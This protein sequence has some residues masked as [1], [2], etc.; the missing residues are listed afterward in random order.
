MKRTFAHRVTAVG[1]AFIAILAGVAL[2]CFL[3]RQGAYTLCGL[4]AM[5]V[6]VV[7][8]ERTVHTE[9]VLTD[10]GV[11]RVSRGRFART[12]DIQ[13]PE[14]TRVMKHHTLLHLADYVLIEYGA[15]H[16]VAVQPAD[17]EHFIN[18]LKKIQRKYDEGEIVQSGS[19]LDDGDAD[20]GSAH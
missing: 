4:L 18:E 2:Y 9:Y 13:V 19:C 11:L 3:Q 17:D 1:V 7:A 20:D 12:I 14:I 15:G 8:V 10:D 16:A 6:A 5:A